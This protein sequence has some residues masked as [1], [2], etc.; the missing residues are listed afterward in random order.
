MSFWHLCALECMSTNCRYVESN[1][2]CL[3]PQLTTRRIH[4]GWQQQVKWQVKWQSRY[5][6]GQLEN[7]EGH[8]EAGKAALS[9][10]AQK[11][12]SRRSAGPG[13]WCLDPS[14]LW[15]SWKRHS[16]CAYLTGVCVDE[17]THL[18]D[19]KS[20]VQINN[21]YACL[22]ARTHA[23]TNTHIHT[24]KGH[25]IWSLFKCKESCNS[26]LNLANAV[27]Q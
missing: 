21:R 6:G 5:L 25:I 4:P 15:K 20:H 11:S 12:E 14:Q 9:H 2:L 16:T 8:E 26:T 27:Q 17:P 18:L 24:Q 19:Q 7:R 23:S 10:A 1:S 22:L 13:D 3:I